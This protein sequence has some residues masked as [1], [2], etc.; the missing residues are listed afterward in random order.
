MSHALPQLQAVA[1]ALLA[2]SGLMSL[3]SAYTALLIRWKSPA[4]LPSSFVLSA[5]R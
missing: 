1:W 5:L 2:F 3:L 4:G